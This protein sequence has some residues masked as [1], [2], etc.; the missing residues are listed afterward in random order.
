MYTVRK[1]VLFHYI[2]S[3]C[4]GIENI[5]EDVKGHNNQYPVDGTF[6]VLTQR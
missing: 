2:D 1:A 4:F 3:Q 5:Q 6:F